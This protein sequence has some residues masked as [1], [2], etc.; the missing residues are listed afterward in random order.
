M[1]HREYAY[2]RLLLFFVV[3]IVKIVASA[4]SAIGFVLNNAA[5]LVAGTIAWL[6]YFAALFIV[7]VPAA[8]RFLR[9]HLHCL[10]TAALTIVIVILTVGIALMLITVTV[11]LTSIQEDNPEGIWSQLFVS[12]DNVF[13][14]NDATAL[15]HQAAQHLLDGKNPYAEANV[16]EAMLEYD[17][18]IDKIT[19]LRQGRLAN[20]FPYPDASQLESLWE[21]V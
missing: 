14:Y 6:A 5:L 1:N 17:G 19:P 3:I 16:I 2:P 8:D 4:L 15:S 9:S 18:S 13:G 20:T 7:A 21:D 10:R 11:G 12:L